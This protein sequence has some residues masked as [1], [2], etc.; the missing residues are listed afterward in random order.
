LDETIAEARR[1]MEVCNA[2][3]YC[4]GYCAVFPAM[5]LRREF[6]EG[7]LTYLANLCHGCRGCYYAC[8]YAPPH[9]FGIN[10]PKV[11]ADLRL[12]TYEKYAW[13]RPLARLFIRNGTVVS[14]GTAIFVALALILTAAFQPPEVI[15]GTHTGEGAF[16]RV[17][18]WAV[19]AGIAGLTSIFSLAAILVSL[20]LFWRDTGASGVPRPGPLARTTSD[21]LTL[22]NLGGSGHG[23][24]DR[25]ESFSMSRRYFHHALFYGFLLCF[26]STTTAWVYDHFYH[27]QAPYPFFSLPVQLGTWGGVGIVAGAGGLLW[28]KITGDPGPV[29]KR[30]LG[31]DYAFLIQ[32]L[33]VALTGLLL[34]AF[35]ATPAMG[36]LLAI[37]LGTVIAL[38]VLLP[39]SKFVHGGY[40]GL[41]LLRSAMEKRAHRLAEMKP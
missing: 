23:C 10:V 28:L 29:S 2:C 26:A 41:A 36:T 1:T 16:Y 4:E 17:I 5:E 6:A 21:I 30:L 37:H 33:L 39:Y 15:L 9:E 31:I 14:I 13:P 25:D 12:E 27:L 3:R 8:Q 11:F 22:R 18:P 19:M 20:V 24:N 7:D 32:L 38:F 40:R 34:L 35:R